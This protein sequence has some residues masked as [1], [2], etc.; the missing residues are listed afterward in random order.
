MLYARMVTHMPELQKKPEP[1]PPLKESVVFGLDLGQISDFTAPAVDQVTE[2]PDANRAGR[3][4]RLHAI[5]HLHRWHLGTAYPQIVADV[6]ALLA[7]VPGSSLALD[8]TG[9]GRA[10]VDLFRAAQLPAAQLPAARLVP[11][12]ITGGNE[13]TRVD[14]GWHVPK[15]DLVGSVQAALQARRLRIAP[16]LR[17]AKTLTKE[18]Q[19]FRVKV[20]LATANE[21]FEAWRERD[22]DDL[23]LAVAMAVWLAGRPTIVDVLRM[24]GWLS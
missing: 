5:R 24:N 16:A 6:K 18:L 9:V 19:T 10:V 8:A 11:I 1:P 2:V 15:K 13:A 22:H 14:R 21:S 20:C 3:V 23:V 12:T 7:Q 4:V 17:E